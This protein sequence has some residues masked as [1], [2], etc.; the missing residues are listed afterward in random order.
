MTRVRNRQQVRAELAEHA[1]ASHKF[2]ADTLEVAPDQSAS[3]FDAPD[4]HSRQ[5]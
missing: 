5:L 1:Q 4:S 3:T 2:R